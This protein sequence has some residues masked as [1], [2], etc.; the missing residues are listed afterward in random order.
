MGNVSS[1]HRRGRNRPVWC[2]MTCNKVKF[3]PMRVSTASGAF[4]AA[5]S[6]WWARR[7]HRVTDSG[8]SGPVILCGAL[9][10][11]YDCPDCAAREK[12][13]EAERKLEEE[14]RKRDKEERKRER[15]KKSK[16]TKTRQKRG[17]KR[18]AQSIA[19]QA[20]GTATPPATEANTKKP[21]RS[22][23]ISP[24]HPRQVS[25][26]PARN[27][28]FEKLS[29]PLQPPHHFPALCSPLL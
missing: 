1:R 2:G 7:R 8:G 14:E 28:A 16:R 13:K 17:S 21:R 19:T 9:R 4:S 26:P 12:A 5:S 27:F 11:M 6:S 3:H 23:R 29:S 20:A 25:T 10:V 24:P 22:A 18:S 15:K